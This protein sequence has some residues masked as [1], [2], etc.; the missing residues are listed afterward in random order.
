MDKNRYFS[1]EIS[2]EVA[3]KKPATNS[4]QPHKINCTAEAE[5]EPNGN[6]ESKI[7]F[8]KLTDEVLENILVLAT[9]TARQTP[10]TYC[11]LVQAC[12]KFRTILELRNLKFSLLFTFSFLMM[13]LKSY[14]ACVVKLT[15]ACIV[16]SVKD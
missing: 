11:S 16:E 7:Y 13:K 2:Q 5:E 6:L 4:N 1:D 9:P 10:E 12:K 8:E 3:E 15:L 14:P